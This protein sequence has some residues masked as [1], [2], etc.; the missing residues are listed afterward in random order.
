MNRKYGAFSSSEDPQKL[1][2][3]VVGVINMIAPLL[4]LAG[5]STQPELGQLAQS[6]GQTITIG[7]AFGGLVWTIF[8]VVRKIVIAAI[9]NFNG[10][11]AQ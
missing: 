9:N 3:T 8:G 11:P 6:I 5:V 4:V 7:W 10:N 2:A 1:A